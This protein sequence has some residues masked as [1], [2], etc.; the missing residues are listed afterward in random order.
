MKSPLV[1]AAGV[2]VATATLTACAPDLTLVPEG[3]GGSGG[4][5]GSSTSGAGG[6][7]NAP[8]PP[9]APHVKELAA[10]SQGGSLTAVSCAQ[11]GLGT[12]WLAGT[13]RTPLTLGATELPNG[14]GDDA[15][16][17]QLGDVEGAMAP[18]QAKAYGGAAN[19]VLAGVA[20][21]SA[22]GVLLGA[23]LTGL[24]AWGDTTYDPAP[25]QHGLLGGVEASLTDGSSRYLAGAGYSAVSDVAVIANLRVAVGTYTGSLDV[26]GVKAPESQESDAFVLQWDAATG[27]VTVHTL[28]G[29]NDQT[30]ARV[31][32]A[33]D[34]KVVVGLS[35]RGTLELPPLGSFE[36]A[37]GQDIALVGLGEDG[38]PTW[39]KTF[40]DA[41]DQALTALGP[42]KDGGFLW[43]AATTGSTW[44]IGQGAFDTSAGVLTARLDDQGNVQW[45]QGFA[46]PGTVKVNSVVETDQGEAVWAGEVGG[47]A[48]WGGLE[49][50]GAAKSHALLAGADEEGKNAW[51]LVLGGD[52][53]QVWNKLLVAG[54]DVVACGT[55]VGEANAGALVT[56]ASDVRTAL[57][58]RVGR[59]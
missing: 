47:S 33:A 22:G 42:T 46:G 35:F 30:G 6:G 12:F 27:A 45:S 44:D 21:R 59:Q 9:E 41:A 40:G 29:A 58:T 52:G 26:D 20:G 32:I 17:A 39:A 56:A 23:N 4:Q 38:A 15:F 43:A 57:W 28:G 5:G 3:A 13:F 48:T 49:L 2:L 31:A 54:D 19:Q 37:G 34:G 50:G 53:E 7:G 55:Y 36:S 10:L 11:D 16:V 24:A 8:E 18:L 14:G 51:A 25:G 1:Q